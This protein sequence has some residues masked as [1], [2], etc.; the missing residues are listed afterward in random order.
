M[1]Y[2]EHEVLRDSRIETLQLRYSKGRF[3]DNSSGGNFSE[4]LEVVRSISLNT[5]TVPVDPVKVNASGC[6]V[7]VDIIGSP[8][9]VQRLHKLFPSPYPLP[10]ASQVHTGVH[11]Q[12]HTTCLVWILLHK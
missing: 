5:A 9:T 10:P 6:R 3:F 8:H 12:F 1:G 4:K 11:L 7:I 2:G